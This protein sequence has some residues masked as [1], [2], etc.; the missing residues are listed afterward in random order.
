M[1]PSISIIIPLFNKS[2][3]IEATLGAFLKQLHVGEE[4]IVVDDFSTDG[5]PD[6]AERL[7][8]GAPG[9]R[10]VK[11]PQNVGPGS[12]RNAGARLAKGTHLLFFDADDIPSSTLLNELRAAIDQF[13]GDHIFT[14]KI[15]FQARGENFTKTNFSETERRRRHAFVSDSIQGRTLCTASSTCVTR[16][17]FDGAEG[18]LEGLRYCEDPELWSRLSAQFD[19]I[20]I[21]NVLA[22][23]QDVPQ[24]LSYGWRGHLGSANPYI[25]TLLKLS[26][27]HGNQYKLLA[28]TMIFRNIFFAKSAGTLRSDISKQL[29]KY[30]KELGCL[31]YFLLKFFNFTPSFFIETFEKWRANL[32]KSKFKR[33][34]NNLN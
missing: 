7:L 5:G 29:Q 4:I 25:D 31:N 6:I 18:F 33:I 15:A 24:S 8:T 9:C 21:N 32:N 2:P 14:Y 28:R 17:A 10:L 23:Y 13:P 34:L 3:Y 22:I 11:M 19:V 27:N 26:L 16:F 1:R 30:R 12:A 20:V